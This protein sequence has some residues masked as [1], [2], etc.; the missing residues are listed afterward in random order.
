MSDAVC[1]LTGARTFLTTNLV[2]LEVLNGDRLV[3]VLS[4]NNPTGV[5][6]ELLPDVVHESVHHWCFNT[7]VGIAMSLNYTRLTEH[8]FTD[9]RPYRIRKLLIRDRTM[10]EVLRPVMEGLACFAEFDVFPDEG[11]L[12]VPPI[13]WLCALAKPRELRQVAGSAAG[14]DDLAKSVLREIRT[15]ESS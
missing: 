13:G 6:P 10:M 3:S 2:H 1:S 12:R 7:P 9:P 8:V 15:S 5:T 14:F 11:N 4:G